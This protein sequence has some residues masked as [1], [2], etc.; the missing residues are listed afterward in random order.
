[1]RK[2]KVKKGKRKISKK[3]FIVTVLLTLV[4]FVFLHHF[5]RLIT[6]A[7]IATW[8]LFNMSEDV[9]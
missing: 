1:M 8:D 7:V 9:G 2:I 3:K 4:G 5:A 6:E